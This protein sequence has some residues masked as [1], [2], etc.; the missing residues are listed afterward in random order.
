[1]NFKRRSSKMEKLGNFPNLEEVDDDGPEFFKVF[2]PTFS[3]KSMWIPPAFVGKFMKRI[4]RVVNV[5]DENGKCWSIGV[6][7]TKEK[8]YF[9]SR[10]WQVFVKEHKLELGD[11]LLFK[12]TSNYNNNASFQV[13]IYAKNGCKKEHKPLHHHHNSTTPA[14]L[15]IIPVHQPGSF[16]EYNEDTKP[17]DEELERVGENYSNGDDDDDDDVQHGTTRNRHFLT[18]LSRKSLQKVRIPRAAL[19]GIRLEKEIV[20][21]CQNN[22]LWRVGTTFDKDGQA[23]IWRKWSEFRKGKNLRNNDKCLFEMIIFDQSNTCKE[24]KVFVIPGC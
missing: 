21:R 14:N 18:T 23:F 2:M 15:Q 10:Q 11:F 6:R 5:R 8:V 12:Y 4:P 22:E 24:M 19:S 17:T 1:M 16:S 13:K 7:K 9:I 3:S 20:L